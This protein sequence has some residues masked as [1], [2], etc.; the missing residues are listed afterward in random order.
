MQP[1]LDWKWANADAVIPIDRGA[2]KERLEV[3]SGWF[4]VCLGS[5]L[6]K[7]AIKSIE[8]CGQELVAFRGDDN[9]VRLVKGYGSDA[10][11]VIE[12]PFHGW[13]DH[14]EGRCSHVAPATA[15]PQQT[16]I[17]SWPV[18][19][20]NGLVMAYHAGDGDAPTWEIPSF[21]SGLKSVH[22]SGIEFAGPHLVHQAQPS[23]T[24]ALLEKLDIALEPEDLTLEMHGLG[25]VV[26]RLRVRWLGLELLTLTALRPIDG[27][28]TEVIAATAI[29]NWRRATVS[30][31]VRELLTHE[32]AA[33][34]DEDVV[35]LERR[36]YGETPLSWRGNGRILRFHR[37][38]E[39]FYGARAA[40]DL[41]GQE[42]RS[43][44]GVLASHCEAQGSNLLRSW[45]SCNRR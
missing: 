27:E 6:E 1:G 15:I 18:C 3:P 19:E 20:V 39:Q 10:T 28:H 21:A 37:W 9:A 5:E 24:Q 12:C 43:L 29:K 8:F 4:A 13:R 35:I 26:A 23:F 14:G 2:K 25:L 7:G 22:S 11:D 40:A 30:R 36:R 32:V 38:A 34:F 44:P 33:D 17:R 31:A 41:M 16:F 42:C 45:W